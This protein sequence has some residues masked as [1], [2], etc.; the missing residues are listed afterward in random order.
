MY[1]EAP[2]PPP[3]KAQNQSFPALPDGWTTAVSPEDGRVYYW[4]THTGR[5]SWVHPNT[6]NNAEHSTN[7]K[8]GIDPMHIEEG[9]S[10]SPSRPASPDPSGSFWTGGTKNFFFGRGHFCSRQEPILSSQSSAASV[11]SGDHPDS[12]PAHPADRMARIEYLDTPWMSNPRKPYNHQFNAMVALVVCF[13]IGV[14]ALM[15][16][17]S[18]DSAWNEGRYSES[19]RHARKAHNY[20][21]IGTGIGIIFWLYWFLFRPGQRFDHWI[22][23]NAFDLHN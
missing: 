14:C 23:Y 8:R 2:P 16:S 5:T 1:Q 15:H 6:L 4:E 11:G 9:Q 18:C 21:C 3:K 20:A 19:V 13:P 12:L 7:T 17:L 22:D 10:S